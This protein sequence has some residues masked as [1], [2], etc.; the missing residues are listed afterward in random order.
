MPAPMVPIGIVAERVAIKTGVIE[1]IQTV[2]ILRC[3]FIM[4]E[5]VLAKLIVSEL[6]SRPV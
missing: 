6:V 5:L 4:S 2:K 1:I 3:E